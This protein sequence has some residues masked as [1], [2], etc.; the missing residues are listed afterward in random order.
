MSGIGDRFCSQAAQRGIMA[1]VL[2]ESKKIPGINN[3]IF[4][5]QTKSEEIIVDFDFDMGNLVRAQK[6][7]EDG[8]I[9]ELNV[10]KLKNKIA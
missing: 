4:F 2:P 9:T 5:D 6:I 3:T 7:E 10:E 8:S 1:P